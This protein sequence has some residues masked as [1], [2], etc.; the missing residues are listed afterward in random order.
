M[1]RK[2]YR[3]LT[4]DVM[5]AEQTSQ[6]YLRPPSFPLTMFFL[7]ITPI[8]CDDDS[9]PLWRSPPAETGG[10]MGD[11]RLRLVSETMLLAE[12]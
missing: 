6:I 10:R 12:Q 5:S 11:G 1:E 9:V 3:S 4:V 7:F 2:G 8:S